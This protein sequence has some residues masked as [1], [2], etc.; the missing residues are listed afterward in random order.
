MWGCLAKV[1]VTTP[2][3]M[4]ISPKMVDCIFIGYAHNSN[5]YKSF[6]YE[7]KNPDVHK[8]IIMESKNALFFEHVFPCRSKEK[9]S[10]FK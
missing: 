3:K 2:K 7:S 4:K 9:S 10:S 5:A 8:N 6:V 1:A